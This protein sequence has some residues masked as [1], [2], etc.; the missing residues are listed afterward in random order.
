MPF[1]F[2]L[3]STT[4]SIATAHELSGRQHERMCAARLC[5]ASAYFRHIVPLHHHIW[6]PSH[7]SH[8]IPAHPPACY[9]PH[10]SAPYCMC[11][12]QVL[13]T[14]YRI[15][16]V[17]LLI[18]PLQIVPLIG[19]SST[20]TEPVHLVPYKTL[21]CF[22]RSCSVRPSYITHYGLFHSSGPAYSSEVR[23]HSPVLHCTIRQSHKSMPVT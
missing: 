6:H 12:P 16:P 5:T 13:A 22:T 21:P 1:R 11:G 3:H 4:V 17:H 18:P 9:C 8:P 23:S 14:S 20:S 7:M 10:T 19:C 15:P 2:L